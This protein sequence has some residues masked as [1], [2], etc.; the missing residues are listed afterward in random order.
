[1][2]VGENNKKLISNY[3]MG[4]IHISKRTKKKKNLRWDICKQTVPEETFKHDYRRNIQ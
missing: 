4:N 3:K 1:M 2:E